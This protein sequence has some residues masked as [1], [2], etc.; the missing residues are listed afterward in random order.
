MTPF[1]ELGLCEPILRAIDEIGYTTPTP[2]Q[3]ESIP[4]LLSGRDLLGGA[5]TGT[6]KTA[7]FGLP[8]LQRLAGEPRDPGPRACRTLILSPTRELAVQI[9]D[10]IGAYSRHLPVSHAV[11]Y[12]GVHQSSQVAAISGGVDILVA[13]PGRLLDLVNQGHVRLWSV[14]VLVLDEADRMLDMGFIDD[15]RQ[16]LACVPRR[17]QAML[18]SAT[19]TARIRGLAGEILTD[20]AEAMVAPASTPAELVDQRVMLVD[21]ANKRALLAD[22]VHELNLDRVLVFAR[23]KIGASRLA[24]QLVREEGLR[25]D[26]IHGDKE[27]WLRDAALQS[28]REGRTRVL[29]ATDVAARGLDID[30]IAYVIN[31]DM[32]HDAED[33]IHRIGRTARAGA[34]GV[35]VSFCDPDELRKLRQIERLIGTDLPIVADQPYHHETAHEQCMRLRESNPQQPA[36]SGQRRRRRGRSGGRRQAAGD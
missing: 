2:I 7:A 18:F 20:P 34:G 27:Q 28:F 36:R 22:M 23:T 3:I 30:R 5:Q 13:T 10:A 8:I 35:A 25:A 33:Y 6:G 12:G 4:H 9:S 29:V 31:Y 32:P 14:E 15:V 24:S 21:Q 16:I 11:I 26:S 19:L 1:A 17:R